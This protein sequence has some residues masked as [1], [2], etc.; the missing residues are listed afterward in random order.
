MPPEKISDNNPHLELMEEKGWAFVQTNGFGKYGAPY[1]DHDY[2]EEF[3]NTPEG[4][5]R[6]DQELRIISW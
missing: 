1:V 2:A 4:H 3:E 5:P 6:S